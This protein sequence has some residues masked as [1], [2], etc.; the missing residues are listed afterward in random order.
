[1]NILTQKFVDVVFDK[2]DYTCMGPH[3]QNKTFPVS[4]LLH[5]T[6]EVQP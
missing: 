1:M 6:E 2:G 5:E 3:Y 4:T